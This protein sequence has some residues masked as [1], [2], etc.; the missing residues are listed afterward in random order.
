M[1]FDV[2]QIISRVSTIESMEK[3]Q[4]DLRAG[5]L[6]QEERVIQLQKTNNILMNSVTS[7]QQLLSIYHQLESMGFGL[8]EL[9]LLF[10]T[11]TEISRENGFSPENAVIKFIDD[12]INQYRYVGGF[13][14][15]LQVLKEETEHVQWELA[16][17]R[18]TLS[19]LEQ[20]NQATSKLLALGLDLTDIVYLAKNLEKEAIKNEHDYHVCHRPKSDTKVKRDTS[21]T[22][23]SIEWKK[24]FNQKLPFTAENE[25]KS[26][27]A[28]NRLKTEL[29]TQVI[30][31]ACF[32]DI[33]I[34][35][36][37]QILWSYCCACMMYD[38]FQIAK[39]VL[40]KQNALLPLV[41]ATKGETVPLNELKR[42][43]I[44]A[45]Q[46]MKHALKKSENTHDSKSEAASTALQDAETALQQL[47]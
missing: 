5:I 22:R 29:I 38:Q 11:V 10:K 24:E 34:Q 4:A 35:I 27:L 36:Q 46:T 45:I 9:D 28:G 42:S 31:I 23:D 18:S 43:V 47:V 15:R 41:A 30:W 39:I 44:I 14:S 25:L 1:G 2:S 32:R 17:I 33:R 8:R 19:D 16:I 12:I 20:V 7:H 37:T 21:T 26:V 3:K 6:N 40:E 13:E